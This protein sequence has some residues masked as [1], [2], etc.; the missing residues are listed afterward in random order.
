MSKE[1]KTYFIYVRST[2]PSIRKPTASATRSRIMA[3]AC[4]R[5]AL[6]GN[7]TATVSAANI[8]RQAIPLLWISLSLMATAPSVII[9]P[10]VAS[11]WRKSSPTACCWSSSLPDCASSTRRPIPSFS[12][13]RITRR[14]SPTA[15]LQESSVARR[16]TY[17]EKVD[18][19]TEGCD[20]NKWTRRE[21]WDRPQ[22]TMRS[23][24]KAW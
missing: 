1:E 9:F 10:T 17:T 14:A 6:S 20:T 23:S 16:W 24:R 15:P 5:I 3:G 2:T 7:A 22:S 13:G 18:T 4:A 21:E 12:F 19:K 8:M 11:L